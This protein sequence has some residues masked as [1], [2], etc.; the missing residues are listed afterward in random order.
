MSKRALVGEAVQRETGAPSIPTPEDPRPVR[1]RSP[2]EN[3]SRV[4]RFHE[5]SWDLS[6]LHPNATLP[7]TNATLTFDDV[8]SLALRHAAKQFI[9]ARLNVALPRGRVF[10]GD[11]MAITGAYSEFRHIWWF[12]KHLESRNIFDLGEVVHEHYLTYVEDLRRHGAS[13][14]TVNHR[15]QVLWRLFAYRSHISGADTVP[16]PWPGY[17]PIDISGPFYRPAE[18]STPRVPAP[19]MMPLLNWALWYVE[20]AG[21]D[22]IRAVREARALKGREF[23]ADPVVSERRLLRWLNERERNGRGLPRRDSELSFISRLMPGQPI[24][25][26]NLNLLAHLSGA[27]HD[28]LKKKRTLMMLNERLSVLGFESGG[29]DA[30]ATAPHPFDR[31]R[32]WRANGFT[33]QTA[34]C[35][36][37]MLMAACWI[38]IAYLSGMRDSEVRNLRRGCRR[39]STV[40]ADT[41]LWV[42]GLAI[43]GQGD[44]G[45][46]ASWVVIAPVHQ[47]IERLEELHDAELIFGWSP[48][49]RETRDGLPTLGLSRTLNEFVQ[50]VNQH[51]STE[52]SQAIPDWEGAPWSLNSRQFRRTIAWYIARRPFGL[53]GLK[54]QYK[55]ADIR[56]SMGYAGTSESGFPGEIEAARSLD[57]TEDLYELYIM[58]SEHGRLL[59]GPR[60][61]RLND[62][63]R[64][65]LAEIDEDDL[66]QAA[67]PDAVRTMLRMIDQRYIAGPL[68]DC[69]FRAERA[70]CLR[71]LPM[72]ERIERDRPILALCQPDD[73]GNGLTRPEQR[74]GWAQA[75]ERSAHFRRTTKGL[76]DAQKIV[77][78]SIEAAYRRRAAEPDL[79][80]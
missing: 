18:N 23:A 2:Y 64:K 39:T 67:K 60:G 15:I 70:R 74:E 17:D 43:K 31:D 9:Y 55:H 19:V 11:T 52:G 29:L 48:Q 62:E 49:D 4:P 50:Y 78:R 10:S 25:F 66:P 68:A 14:L 41:R 58:H 54:R 45:L 79:T 27:R 42:D 21:P 80:T 71:H 24:A 34:D 30:V 38:V 8:E 51:H 13:N 36:G 7:R 59:G 12:F 44:T 6:Q 47:A 3:E 20:E 57:A 65:I 28:F 56:T 33:I 1:T 72:S 53:I 22:I 5:S 32:A 61:E 35:A 77:S 75:A 73:C 76:D 16:R 37:R 69:L 26:L 63:F 40:G 46:D